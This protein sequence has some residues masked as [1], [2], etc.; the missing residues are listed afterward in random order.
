MHYVITLQSDWCY[1]IFCNAY[2]FETRPSIL[3]LGTGHALLV[4]HV[5]QSS[6]IKCNDFLSELR[7]IRVRWLAV[8]RSS[9]SSS[10]T[11][12]RAR[13]LPTDKLSPPAPH[14]LAHP[15][16]QCPLLA[17]RPTLSDSRVAAVPM[18]SL[19]HHSSAIQ[20]ATRYCFTYALLSQHLSSLTMCSLMLKVMNSVEF[21]AWSGWWM[22]YAPISRLLLETCSPHLRVL[23]GRL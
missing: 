23:S 19:T 22:L 2:R 6:V 20:P 3:G 5:L 17:Y 1:M 8:T 10:V 4:V 11:P 16:V 12:T 18:V 13:V 14:L 15:V 21:P 7:A 9:T